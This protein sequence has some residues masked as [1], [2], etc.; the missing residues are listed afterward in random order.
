MYKS[1][2]TVFQKKKKKKSSDLQWKSKCERQNCEL[3][4]RREKCSL[5][6]IFKKNIIIRP[7]TCKHACNSVWIDI[8]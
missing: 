8:A 6:T 7:V 2:Q 1:N 4:F 5:G 3:L